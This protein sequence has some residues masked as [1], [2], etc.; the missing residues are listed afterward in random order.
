M[1]CYGV[2]DRPDGCLWLCDVC[3]LGPPPL[4]PTP[5]PS[6]LGFAPSLPTAVTCQCGHA[7]L[8]G[9]DAI[10]AA[11]STCTCM[12]G[13]LAHGRIAWPRR[14]GPAARV[15]AVPARG[16]RAQA[17]RG[18]ALG[19]RRVRAVGARDRAGPRQRPYPG[20]GLRTQGAL[21]AA[22]R[23]PYPARRALVVGCAPR[24]CGSNSLHTRLAWRQLFLCS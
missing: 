17:L 6:R 15:R 24:A 18:R 16:R 9:E 23:I 12:R 11:T 4:P 22:R 14:P 13:N 2:R 1:D 20:V 19:A 3:A 8:D 21:P 7:A 10:S 5:L